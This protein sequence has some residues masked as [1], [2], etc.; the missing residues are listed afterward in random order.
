MK[1]ELAAQIAE[2]QEKHKGLAQVLEAEHETVLAGPLPFE[3]SADGHASITA[4]FEIELCIPSQCPDGLQ[5]TRETGGEID[6]GY[7]HVYTDG[8]LCLAVPIAERLVF[9]RQPSLLGFV[10]NLVIPYLYG[11][12]HWKEYGEHPFGE[13]K[14]GA[15][16]IV[17]C[18][19][20]TLKLIDEVGALAVVLF[21]FEHGYRDHHDCPCGSGL[22]VWK[23]HGSMLRDLHRH[24]TPETLRYDLQAV[25]GHC[26]EKLTEGRLSLP[27][28]LMRRIR[29]LVD[30]GK[31]RAGF[32]TP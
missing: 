28:P 27:A 11:Y 19:V 2:L 15:E 6:G 17:R 30:G 3:A 7:E 29:R 10:N 16:G 4:S 20:D 12:D 9:S 23:C 22:K 13:Q 26:G 25:L 21:L 1:T 14:H 18:Y 32:W 24:H 5:R 8:T 31:R